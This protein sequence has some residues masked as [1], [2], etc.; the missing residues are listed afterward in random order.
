[1]ATATGRDARWVAAAIGFYLVVVAL[2]VWFEHRHDRVRA[3]AEIDQRLLI[4]A[5]GVAHVLPEDFHDR[6]TGPDAIPPEEDLRNQQAL[7]V[8]AEATGVRYAWTDIAV[9]GTFYITAC[10]RTEQSDEPG[11]ETDYF[12]AYPDVSPAEFR[13]LRTGEAQFATITDRWGTFRA[14]FVPRP[15]PGG[16]PYIA[17]AVYMLEDVEAALWAGTRRLL[18]IAVLLLAAIIPLFAAYR[19]L[20]DRQSARLSAARDAL[21]GGRRRLETILDSIH[22]AVIA[23]DRDGAISHVNPV[24]T[25]L[26]GR[27][28]AELRGCALDEVVALHDA[29]TDEPLPGLA[30]QVRERQAPVVLPGGIC[31]RRPDGTEVT[32]AATAAPIGGTDAVES[33]GVVAVL[34][35][36]T[37]QARTEARLRQSQ[38]L[39]SVGRLAGG[40]AHDFNNL[41]MAIL[42]SVELLDDR[43]AGQPEMATDLDRIRTAGR[44]AAELTRQLLEFSRRQPR[45]SRIVDL[46]EVVHETAVLLDHSLDRSIE[47]DVQ[48]DAARSQVLGDQA[49][50]GSVL[51]NLAINARDAMAEGGIL[52]IRT[53]NCEGEEG[54]LAGRDLVELTVTDTGGGMSAEVR[55]RVFE[56]FFTTKE[57]GRG[58]GLG[59]AVV[60]GA[61]RDLGGAIDVWSELQAGTT[62][63]IVLPVVHAS[64]TRDTQRRGSDD[65]AAV[66]QGRRL[67]LVED[68]PDLR[69][70]ARR[71]L[72]RYGC[73]VEVAGDG[74]AAERILSDGD[75]TRFDAAVIDL[76]MP[77]RDGIG[78][79]AVLRDLDPD[80]PVLVCSGYDV[81][82]RAA[83]LLEQP[84]TAYLTKPYDRH[85]LAAALADLLRQRG[86][87]MA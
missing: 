4:V 71:V 9:D 26:L 43:L 5:E 17:G 23:T 53:R 80:L 62:F 86:R 67:L 72:T 55:E 38:R 66:L 21:E 34:R 28:E 35:D 48:L 56:P 79:F 30:D 50:L 7:T 24:A 1:M 59:M 22:E 61:V 76:M 13:A 46:H 40:V 81:S 19:R 82:L 64:R 84:R 74:V 60:Y 18:V 42:G 33:A 25:G 16:R 54:D 75:P 31:L 44:R 11:L 65:D 14:A 32:V 37:E 41:L 3:L 29:G 45:S 69:E 15:S 58:T 87:A 57:V 68:E 2:I 51:M 10:N 70:L 27:P 83:D 8:Y 52:T 49:R 77:R 85:S 6:A 47:M 73:E 78:T 20:A 36:V 39:E 63:R 12:V